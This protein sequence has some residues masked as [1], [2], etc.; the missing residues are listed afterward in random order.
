MRRLDK[1]NA[2]QALHDSYLI[3]C[4]TEAL[5]FDLDEE[6]IELLEEEL[7]KRSIDITLYQSNRGSVSAVN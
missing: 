6:F 1:M 2:L 3:E 7:G 5:K 4:Y